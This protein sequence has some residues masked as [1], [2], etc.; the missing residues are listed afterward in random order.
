MEILFKRWD[1]LHSSYHQE[2]STNPLS[3][4]QIW[5]AT[6]SIQRDP[7][8]T[9]FSSDLKHYQGALQTEGNARGPAKWA[10]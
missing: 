5:G 1:K 4:Q 7:A 9:H 8:S 2:G 10:E 3:L 6:Y